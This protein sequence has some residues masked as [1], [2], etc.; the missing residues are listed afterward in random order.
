MLLWQPGPVDLPDLAALRPLVPGR[1]LG[2]TGSP[3]AGKSTVAA[4]L[5]QEWG[6][7][8]VPMDEFHCADVELR[9]RGAC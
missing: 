5:A 8:G 9:R 7:V 2:I 3:G 6:A 4:R 1:L